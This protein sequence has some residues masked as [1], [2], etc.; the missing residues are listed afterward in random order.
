MGL[1]GVS[2]WTGLL[3]EVGCVGVKVIDGVVIHGCGGGKCYALNFFMTPHY[4]PG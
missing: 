3:S 1:K 2:D 4:T